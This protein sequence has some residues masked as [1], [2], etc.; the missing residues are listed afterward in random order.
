MTV[1]DWC[2]WNKSTVSGACGS[3][4]HVRSLPGLRTSPLTLDHMALHQARRCV[5]ARKRHAFT[6]LVRCRAIPAGGIDGHAD[7]CFPA[8]NGTGSDMQKTWSIDEERLHPIVPMPRPT[9]RNETSI[10]DAGGRQTRNIE[11]ENALVATGFP[12]RITRSCSR[13]SVVLAR[14]A[15]RNP[16]RRSASI[17]VTR[18]ARSAVCFA[19]NAMLHLV[20][21]ET[22][23]ASRGRRRRIWR[24]R[25]AMSG[26][27]TGEQQNPSLKGFSGESLPRT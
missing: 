10:S 12:C 23:R 3:T 25:K 5:R 20:S 15:G 16:N 1:I 19:A 18:P 8:A 2:R 9:R 13:D 24:L 26:R 21:T 4:I 14:S 6:H 27:R 11:K 17:I 22:T 7:Q